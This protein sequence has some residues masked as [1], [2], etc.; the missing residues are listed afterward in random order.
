MDASS[1]QIGLL[2]GGVAGAVGSLQSGYASSAAAGYNAKVAQENAQLATQNAA[3]TGAE[4]EQAYGIAGLKATQQGGAIKTAQAANNIDINSMSA[5]AVQK[6]Q[7]QEGML[8]EANIR[9]NAARQAYGFETQATSDLAQSALL[10]SQATQ[11]I[12]AGFI[13]AGTSLAKAGGESGIYKSGDGSSSGVD[14]TAA[15]KGP[16][17]SNNIQTFLGSETTD[18]FNLWQTTGNTTTNLFPGL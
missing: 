13:G 3:W 17:A 1:G 12:A 15:F 6:G 5:R 14:N 10:K 16:T 8:N 18:N 9:S 11:D 4:G 2:G 7:A